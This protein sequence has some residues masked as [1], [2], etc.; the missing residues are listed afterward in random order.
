MEL[1][2]ESDCKK[3][4]HFSKEGLQGG[5]IMSQVE[6]NYKMEHL[7]EKN[8]FSKEDILKMTD[9]QIEYFHW[10]Y[11]EETVYDLM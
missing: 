6:R 9:E 3:V 1:V 7:W 8:K 11:F 5:F 2:K 4:K 10:L